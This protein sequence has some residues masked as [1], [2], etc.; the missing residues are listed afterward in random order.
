MD[1]DNC[2]Y[3]WHLKVKNKKTTKKKGFFSSLLSSIGLTSKI[4]ILKKKI[5]KGAL[6]GNNTISW[7]PN[8]KQIV[9]GNS[10][11]VLLWDLEKIISNTNT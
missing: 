7:N 4:K 6:A 1:V 3:L 11:K 2:I 10:N 5:L 9:S 8:G